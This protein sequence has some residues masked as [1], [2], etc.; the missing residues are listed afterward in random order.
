MKRW[1]KGQKNH[2]H[3]VQQIVN[4]QAWLITSMY[5]SIL[6]HLLLCKAG[7]ILA[8]ILLD[9]HQRQYTHRLLSLP[10]VHPTKKIVPI[11]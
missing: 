8:S 3:I 10:N 9:Y 1:W 6:I 2:K 11:S 4:R 5:S 7:L